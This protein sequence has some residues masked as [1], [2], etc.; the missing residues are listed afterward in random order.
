MYM[1]MHM[2]MYMY[3]Y[4]YLHMCMY[5]YMYMHMF[6]CVYVYVY[7][8]IYLHIYIYIYIIEMYIYIYM[9][10]YKCIYVY[11]YICIYSPMISLTI[12]LSH[13]GW[14]PHFQHPMVPPG[15]A[16]GPLP[17]QPEGLWSPRKLPGCR[18]VPV[19]PVGKPWETHG[20]MVVEWDFMD[21]LWI[22]YG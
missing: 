3:M 11:I 22:I 7:I 2:Y 19:K 20:K 12:N 6:T 8:Y 21:N 9:Y 14:I 4:M 13:V 15:R 1:Y 5:M 18:E 17:K 16:A 10:I